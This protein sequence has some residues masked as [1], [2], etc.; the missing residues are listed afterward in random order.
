MQASRV[1]PRESSPLVHQSLDATQSS[2]PVTVI[3]SHASRSHSSFRLVQIIAVR[4]KHACRS[5]EPRR[6][7]PTKFVS[8]QGMVCARSNPHDQ[9]SGSWRIE[10]PSCAHRCTQPS[11]WHELCD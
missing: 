9:D 5:S 3:V 2:R 1:Q 4:V 8:E 6:S 7:V 10:T 11:G